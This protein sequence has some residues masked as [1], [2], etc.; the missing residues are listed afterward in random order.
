MPQQ[1]ALGLKHVRNGSHDVAAHRLQSGREQLYHHPAIV[2][3]DNQGGNAIALGVDHPI[4]RGVYAGTSR[5]AG[6]ESFT[7]PADVDGPLG[8]FKQAE[9]DLGSGREDGLADELVPGVVDRHETGRL[10]SGRDVA[11]IDPRMTARPALGTARCHAGPFTTHGF[12][13]RSGRSTVA[14]LR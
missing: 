3:V 12:P 7:P 13:A 11:A 10:R 2:P 14:S 4:G 8:T 9:L 5:K 6:R 1:D